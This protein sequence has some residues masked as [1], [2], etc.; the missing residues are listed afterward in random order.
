M[1]AAAKLYQMDKLSSGQAAQ[2][3]GIPRLSFLHALADYGVP[4]FDLNE[5]ERRRD[6]ENA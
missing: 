4:I 6:F 2:L 1:A 5:E 3:A